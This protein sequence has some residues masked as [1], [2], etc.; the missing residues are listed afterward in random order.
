MATIILLLALLIFILQLETAQNWLKEKSTSYL[1]QK[2]GAKFY[3]GHIKT[4][5]LSSLSLQDLLIEDRSHQQLLKIGQLDLQFKLLDIVQNKIVVNSIQVDTVQVFIKRSESDSNFNFDFIAKAFS[6]NDK[7]VVEKTK[8]NNNYQI[9]V[10]RFEVKEFSFVMDDKWG[11]QFY[12]ISSKELKGITKKIDLAK[13]EFHINSLML[14]ELKAEAY[15]GNHSKLSSAENTTSSTLPIIKLDTLEIGIKQLKLEMESVNTKLFA[16]ANKIVV[17]NLELNGVKHKLDLK[18]MELVGKRADF[19]MKNNNSGSSKTIDTSFK[20]KKDIYTL[21]IEHLRFAED[22]MHI[23]VNPK[24][25]SQKNVVDFQNI[26]LKQFELEVDNINTWNDIYTAQLK[27]LKF[28]ERSGFSVEHF[29]ADIQ[30]SDNETKI[31]NLDLKTTH[32][33]LKADVKANY[34]SVTALEK[35]MGIAK[36]DANFKLIHIN[37]IDLAYLGLNKL[38]NP[39]AQKML[40]SDLDFSGK[41]KG[42]INNL[43]VNDLKLRNSG[44]DVQLSGRIQGLPDLNKMTSVV[45]IKTISGSAEKLKALLPANS[46]P[47]N[48]KL[49]EKFAISGKFQG[50]MKD[51]NFDIVF[52]SSDGDIALK[53]WLKELDSQEKYAY[54]VHANTKGFHVERILN[55]SMY[56][57]T[58]FEMVASGK[59]IS[60]NKVAANIEIDFPEIFLMGYTYHNLTIK[61]NVHNSLV[62]LEILA[63]DKAFQTS[64]NIRYSLD[65]LHPSLF[66]DLNVTKLDLFTLGFVTDSLVI[67]T[68]VK[69]DLDLVNQNHI[70]GTIFLPDLIIEAMGEKVK[71]D[72]CYLNSSYK[73][74]TQK[75]EVKLPFSKISLDGKYQIASLP[76]ITKQIVVSY[77]TKS[78]VEKNKSE[79]PE[80]I[81]DVDFLLND[82]P[83]LHNVFPELGDFKGLAISGKLDAKKRGLFLLGIMPFVQYGSLHIDSTFF[84]SGIYND[85]LHL[86]LISSNIN[87]SALNVHHAYL[88]TH[89]KDGAINL[90]LKIFNSEDIVTYDINGTIDNDENSYLL[91]LKDSILLNNERW[92]T[93][94]NNAI[95][96]ESVSSINTNLELNSGIKKFMAIS[97]P[98]SKGYPMKLELDDFPISTFT[99]IN[100]SDTAMI[101]GIINGSLNLEHIKPFRFTGNVELD[102]VTTYGNGIGSINI[103]A[104]NDRNE[105]IQASMQL[106][107]YGNAASLNTLIKDDGNISGDL[108]IDSLS[109]SSIG[110]LL[111]KYFSNLSGIANGELKF[112]GTVT[113]PIINGD[114]YIRAAQAIYNDYNTYARIDSGVVRFT[115]RGITLNDLIVK[116]SSNNLAKINGIV[117]TQNYFDY[118][119]DLD[120]DTDHFMAVNKKRNKEQHIYGPISVSSDIKLLSKR[121][122]LFVTGDVVVDDNSMVNFEMEDESANL[123][124]SDGI[125][126]YYNSLKKVTAIQKLKDVHETV[127]KEK[128]LKMAFDLNLEITN[129]S[130]L[131]II[132]DQ[133]GGDYLKA[134]GDAN[135][136][137]TEN[138]NGKMSV[139]GMYSVESGEYI[140]SLNEF[141]KRKF[142]IQ[143]GGTIKWDGNPMN[144]VIDLTALYNVTTSVESLLA[145]A[146]SVS[147]DAYKQRL[148]FEILLSLKNKMTKPDI[149]FKLDMPEKDRNAMEGTV[150][151]RVK[152]INLQESELNKQV[153]GLLVLNS[154]IPQNPLA[155]AGSGFSLDVESTARTTAGKLL[156]QQ[157]NNLAGALIKDFDL[158]FDLNSTTDYTSG[159]KQGQTDLA[160]NVSK[161]LFNERTIVTVGSTF[162][163]EGSDDHK[164]NTSGFAGNV[165]VEYKIT[166][167]GKYRAKVYRNNQYE[168]VIDGQVVQ[169]GLS[170]VLF[171]DF[172]KYRE[173]FQFRN[174]K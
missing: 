168:T 13:A 172:N 153:M 55:D 157:M 58:S 33:V 61:S 130:T 96:Y 69:T 140:L 97:L 74:N 60:L 112:N 5:F 117:I 125:I 159:A 91:H 147:N 25:R 22:S 115:D 167:N 170:F 164:H 50:G 84:T 135:L 64:G 133:E 18:K 127:Y 8:S 131:N 20:S 124:S 16:D 37:K 166:P 75:I 109:F 107:G 23:Q 71:L 118:Q 82:H 94:K 81:A 106:V 80:C 113:K 129:K 158:S 161:K 77:I 32:S 79:L 114:V 63:N 43:T 66:T 104:A 87:Y 144:G 155:S 152:Q 53:G 93:N 42:Q 119:Y 39:Y 83:V 108:K 78:T 103:V 29:N 171:V 149:H 45:N 132:L 99:K 21:K 163:L 137:V 15:N 10:G 143:K 102:N 126:E 100:Q 173:L 27:N 24:L 11:D 121:N 52:A 156:S 145:S 47:S 38:A 28:Q 51:P 68:K 85:S 90:G 6:N 26:I 89:A 86:D 76:E 98:G 150:Y 128:P 65:S 35:N 136:S 154:F 14:S 162:A 116:D 141:I 12:N 44:F 4:N 46:I 31:E 59:G 40:A 160:V 19:E 111:K 72:S 174:R 36:V 49:P 54:D 122:I 92:Y 34:P 1:S 62:D 2:I 148:P 88:S 110:P 57:E 67:A 41:A 139:F 48:I 17:R 138:E 7:Q 169:T 70:S 56:G 151:A 165:S 3:I 101:D 142:Q 123:E 9:Q 134:S 120:I 30:Y 105:N 95:R 73:N 146:Q